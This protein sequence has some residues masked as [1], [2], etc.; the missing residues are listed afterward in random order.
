VAKLVIMAMDPTGVAQ[1]LLDIQSATL[2]MPTTSL[3]FAVGIA[4]MGV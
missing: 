1:Y 2:N 4:V 3:I